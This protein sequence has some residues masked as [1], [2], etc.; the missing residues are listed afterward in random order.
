MDRGGTILRVYVVGDLTVVA[1][2]GRVVTPKG[3]KARALVA[4]LALSTNF[5][6]TRQQLQDKLWSTRSPEQGAVSLRQALSEI[7]S[8]F[9]NFRDCLV[10][11]RRKVWLDPERVDVVFGLVPSARRGSSPAKLLEDLDPPD[12]E[13]E[14]W[15]REQTSL[16]EASLEGTIRTQR[17]PPPVP[18]ENSLARERSPIAPPQLFLDAAAV[19]SSEKGIGLFADTLTDLIA[20]SVSEMS[21]VDVLDRRKLSPG[22]AQAS[23]E[24]P[25]D[26]SVHTEVVES[27]GGFACR[28]VL[29]ARERNKVLWT[30]SF[31]VGGAIT[32]EEPAALREL[33]QIVEAV[34]KNAFC[35]KPRH[36]DG[37][38]ASTL[39]RRGMSLLFELKHDKALLADQLFERAYAIEP[40]GIYLAWRAYLRTY[41]L[42]EFITSNPERI[43]EEA[44]EFMGQ[45]LE[46]EPTNSYV[47][48][49]AAQVHSIVRRSPV[50]A[51]ELAERSI[52]L[53]RANPM[54]WACL[55]IAECYLGRSQV[56]MEH[57]LLARELAGATPFRFQVSALAC[58]A[59][60]MA[61]AVDHAILLGEASHGLAPRF[62]P[63]LRF[64]SALYLLKNQH[65]Q[66]QAM[67]DKLKA[68]EP[69][70][71]YELLRDKSYPVS[72]L[73][74]SGLLQNLPARE[75]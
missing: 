48:A 16:Y 63:P 10:A 8:A 28:V 73:H 53:N 18:V 46:L 49:F 12:P 37:M 6:R 20:R 44:V 33:N 23:V 38:L 69:N 25:Q 47:A 56:G 55:G 62:K 30:S 68:Y 13:F 2:D 14:D 45:A 15:L 39:C 64:L 51:F 32:I 11:D 36:E 70:F 71:S 26:L 31:K 74:R 7:R 42:M 60:T 67:V 72:S 40:R 58:I 34:L 4:L 9:G 41:L 29:A 54:G 43:A 5:R 22:S 1:S 3:S 65:E 19:S 50:A 27:A 66:S 21:T 52:Q 59:A 35:G 57:A 61:G 75:I 17:W 24:R